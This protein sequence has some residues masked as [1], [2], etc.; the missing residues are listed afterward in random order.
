[1]KKSNKVSLVIVLTLS[2]SYLLFSNENFVKQNYKTSEE[3][4][5]NIN[6]FAVKEKIMHGASIDIDRLA[7]RKSI[8]D[9]NKSNKRSLFVDSNDGYNYETSLNI[10][11]E[12]ELEDKNSPVLVENLF[13]E[14]NMPIVSSTQP[15]NIENNLLSSNDNPR[16]NDKLTV[17]NENLTENEKLI[18]KNDNKIEYLYQLDNNDFEYNKIDSNSPILINEIN[19]HQNPSADTNEGKIIE[20]KVN[21]SFVENKEIRN[22]LIEKSNSN[23]IEKIKDTIIKNSESIEEITSNNLENN[24]NK[25]AKKKE[26]SKYGPK[27]D[28]IKKNELKEQKKQFDELSSN[29]NKASN[30]NHFKASLN[31]L[32]NDLEKQETIRKNNKFD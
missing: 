14:N 19:L 23:I 21:N 18:I 1:M 29:S 27:E 24:K 10:N 8:I 12:N 31:K 7:F 9:K 2:L 11:E 13:T 3:T 17:S 5:V 15:E 16:E 20:T 26:N 30:D 22:S 6:E 25:D 4:S 32:D 28:K